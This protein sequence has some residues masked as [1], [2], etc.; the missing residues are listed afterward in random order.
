MALRLFVF[1]DD[2]GAKSLKSI[3]VSNRKFA[4]FAAG[5]LSLLTLLYVIG[6]AVPAV[7]W[8]MAFAAPTTKAT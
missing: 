6:V 4:V 5:F 3:C 2:S 1:L 8:L 7:K